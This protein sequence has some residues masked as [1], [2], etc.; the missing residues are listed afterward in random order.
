MNE[1]ILNYF[2]NLTV[3]QL[4]NWIHCAACPNT[5][6][7][8]VYTEF[9]LIGRNKV[10]NCEKHSPHTYTNSRLNALKYNNIHTKQIQCRREIVLRI[11]FETALGIYLHTIRKL[12]SLQIFSN[13]FSGGTAP[14]NH[15]KNMHPK[16]PPTSYTPANTMEYSINNYTLDRQI[17]TLIRCFWVRYAGMGYNS[18]FAERSYGCGRDAHAYEQK[19]MNVCW[20]FNIIILRWIEYFLKTCFPNTQ[21]RVLCMCVCV[22]V[23]VCI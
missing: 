2:H 3:A 20:T 13:G 5:I 14:P 1:Q 23:A 7:I 17:E 9:I 12:F 19:E 10:N 21:L 18:L 4:I 16:R 11:V 8:L 22:C 15:V 6:I